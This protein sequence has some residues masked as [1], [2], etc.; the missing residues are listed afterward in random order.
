MDQPGYVFFKYFEC[1]NFFAIIIKRPEITYAI[2]KSY[3][4]EKMND[5]KELYS[6]VESNYIRTVE[7]SDLILG[8]TTDGELI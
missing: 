8:F 4:D 6:L 7:E 2:S 1:N 5:D 3:F